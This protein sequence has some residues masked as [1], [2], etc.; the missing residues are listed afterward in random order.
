MRELEKLFVYGTLKDPDIQEKI[1]GRTVEG[2]LDVL[3]NYKKS[4]IEIHGK[5]YPIV[6]PDSNS[7]VEGLVISVTLEELN[8]IDEYE[9]EAYKR[10]KVT[11]KSRELVWT[12]QK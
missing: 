6:E 12:Y 2:F 4:E 1:I 3:E 11:L 5:I 10:K 7:L 8:L 9:T